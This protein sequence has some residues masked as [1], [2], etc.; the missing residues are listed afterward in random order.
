MRQREADREAGADLAHRVAAGARLAEA[1]V[2]AEVVVGLPDRADEPRGR[3]RRADLGLVE[4]LG[5]RAHLPGDRSLDDRADEEVRIVVARA[6][7]GAVEMDGAPVE[8][9]RHDA[10]EARAEAVAA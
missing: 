1:D 2:E 4:E 5:D 9:L 10:G 3:G 6:R 7:G 8:A